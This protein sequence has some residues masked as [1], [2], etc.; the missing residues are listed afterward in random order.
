MSKPYT[1]LA[2]LAS[3]LRACIL[4]LPA[5]FAGCAGTQ[6]PELSF[7]DTDVTNAESQYSSC[8]YSAVDR[9]VGSPAGADDIVAAAE[10]DCRPRYLEYAELVRAKS[11]AGADTQPE[12]QFANDRADG[13]LRSK[14]SELRKALQG[15]I[16]LK[17]LGGESKGVGRTP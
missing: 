1:T 9:R 7:V 17:A 14:Q 2:S 8:V 11:A 6:H 4:L 5:L 13:Y 3:H 10:G 15:R 12:K 16:A